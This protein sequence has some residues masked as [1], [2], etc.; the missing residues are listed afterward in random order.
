[1]KSIVIYG[2]GDVVRLAAGA[3]AEANAFAAVNE[4]GVARRLHGSPLSNLATTR[5]GRLPATV[6]EFDA[7]YPGLEDWYA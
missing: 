3:E 1:M 2:P 7:A 5:D 6:A 4:G